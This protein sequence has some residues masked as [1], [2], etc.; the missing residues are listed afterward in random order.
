M[1][2]KSSLGSRKHKGLG[3]RVWIPIFP[4]TRMGLSL[5]QK[6]LSWAQV[7]FEMEVR[8]GVVGQVFHH[9]IDSQLGPQPLKPRSPWIPVTCL[10]R[11]TGRTVHTWKW[12]GFF[13]LRTTLPLFLF[14]ISPAWEKKNSKISRDWLRGRGQSEGK[15]YLIHP[16]ARLRSSWTQMLSIFIKRVIFSKA[17]YMEFNQSSQILHLV[18]LWPF[19]SEESHLC[20]DGNGC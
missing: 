4:K 6:L 18:S 5:S 17:F 16:R 1:R 11:Q 13:L 14:F 10:S 19:L 9:H 3:S 12:T 15:C 8:G 2:V 20:H 7:A